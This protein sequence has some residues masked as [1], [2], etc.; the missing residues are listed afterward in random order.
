MIDQDDVPQGLWAELRD[1]GAFGKVWTL[2]VVAF[3]VAR[4]VVVWPVLDKYGVNPWWFLL[5]DVGTAPFYGVGQA[6]GVKILRNERRPMRDAVPWVAMV[7]VSFLAPYLYLLASAGHLPSYVIIGVVLWM[8]VFGALGA[9]RMAR[10]VSV[11][12]VTT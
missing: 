5:L 4:A 8:L 3:C 7:I 9:F 11:E 1:L 2:T 12:P 10:E 6:M